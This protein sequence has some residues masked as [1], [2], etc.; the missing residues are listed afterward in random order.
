MTRTQLDRLGNRIRNGNISDED[1]RLL[2]EY[3]LSFADAYDSIIRAIREQLLLEPTG[4]PA[5]STTSIADKLFRESIRLS[6]IQDIAGCR[7][8]VSDISEQY[9]V[10][11]SLQDLFENVNVIDR[12]NQ[13]SHGYR[14]VHVIVKVDGK[15]VEIQ[16]RT[17]LQ[18]VWA[19]LSEKISDI[20]DP[21]IK[22]GGGDESAQRILMGAS[23]LVSQDEALQSLFAETVRQLALANDAS[24]ESGEKV[25]RL[26]Q[27]I[28]VARDLVYV[29][30][31]DTIE[32][33]E[34]KEGFLNDIS[35]RI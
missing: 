32:N 21:A 3:R 14:A 23:S 25:E 24:E 12:R 35:D 11:Q 20:R 4:R 19:E 26:R 29:F 17:S 8:V 27:R 6:Q 13:P 18:H 15:L 31:N 2:D 34:K 7:L 5:K 22:Y 1:L 28:N 16:V 30:L 10:V 9:S 33:L